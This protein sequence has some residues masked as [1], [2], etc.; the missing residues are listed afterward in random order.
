M[1]D[2]LQELKHNFLLGLCFG[3]IIKL[4]DEVISSAK[5]LITQRASR[6]FAAAWLLRGLWPSSAV[7][8]LYFLESVEQGWGV[9]GG[10]DPKMD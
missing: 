2:G 4:D 10:E 1:S 7:C 8:A 5:N 6:G 9:H 3:R